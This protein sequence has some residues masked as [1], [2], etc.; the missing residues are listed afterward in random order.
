VDGNVLTY[1]VRETTSVTP[2]DSETVMNSGY[3]LTLYT[4]TWDT[5]ERI[6]VFCERTGGTIPGENE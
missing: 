2:D 6:T 4:C 5:T 3:A 1:T